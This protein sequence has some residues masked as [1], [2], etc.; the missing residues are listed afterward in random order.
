MCSANQLEGKH[1]HM[2][3]N[4]TSFHSNIWKFLQVLKSEQALTNVTI[5]QM[6]AGHAEPPLR[7]QC[8]DA[9]E[10]IT[11]IVQKFANRLTLDYFRGIAQNLKF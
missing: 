1:N 7:K 11:T 9:N 5:D 3:A 8:R 10:R 4:K 2:Q 6:R